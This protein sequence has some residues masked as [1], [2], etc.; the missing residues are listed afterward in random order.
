METVSYLDFPNCLK[1]S[2]G[3]AEIVVTTDL[4]PRVLWYGLSGGENVL[5][6]CLADVIKTELGE[7][8]PYGGHRLWVAP[9]NMPKSYVPDSA[10]LE[11]YEGDG[12]S[13]RLMQRAEAAT[14]LQKELTVTLDAEGS[15]VTLRH[16]ITNRGEVEVEVSA[17]ALTIMRGGGVAIVP[18]EPYGPHPDFLL[19]ARPLALWHYTDLSDPRYTFGRKFVS[20]RSEKGRKEPQKIGVG[21]RQGWAAYHV[22]ET[23]F[24]K[25]FGYEE[26]ARYPDCGSNNEVFTAGAFIEV[27]SL[28][29]LRHL[30][31]GES[32]EH[33]ERW[34]LHGG[35]RVGVGA[36]DAA[37]EAAIGL[38][39][40]QTMGG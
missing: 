3:R 16:R 2:N 19:P 13:V 29:P 23:L 11:S 1:L 10:P 25:R 27:E 15:G 5:G 30:Q 7:W 37:L 32:V 17:W 28:S 14:G 20:V 39:V 24:V 4:G 35:V 12:H 31:F 36:D 8:K 38:L 34:S 21:N 22:G 40:T 33:V 6:E 26:G 18:Q 9:E